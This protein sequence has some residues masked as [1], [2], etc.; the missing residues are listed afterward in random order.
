LESGTPVADIG[1]GR[2]GAEDWIL[3]IV[4]CFDDGE[5]GDDAEMAL[6]LLSGGLWAVDCL[7]ASEPGRLRYLASY[8]G[9]VLN[10]YRGGSGA[11]GS[12]L[13]DSYVAGVPFLVDGPE[14]AEFFPGGSERSS[15]WF[16]ANDQELSF[17]VDD[18]VSLMSFDYAGVAA[19]MKRRGY[20]IYPQ[21]LGPKGQVLLETPLGCI[22][23]D[24]ILKAGEVTI[25]PLGMIP[26]DEEKL[27]AIGSHLNRFLEV[28]YL[29]T[30]VD[31]ADD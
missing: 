25:R 1:E 4:N 28:G 18:L 16:R 27:I 10:R 2:Y 20:G 23:A 17:L 15:Q 21:I 19:E 6:S 14:I 24:R 26:G 13:F 9:L 30:T 3:T 11:F 12:F 7:R 31:D 5:L 22:L 29:A 8:R